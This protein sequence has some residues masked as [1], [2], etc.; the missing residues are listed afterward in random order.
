MCRVWSCLVVAY[1][2]PLSSLL[3]PAQVPRSLPL[4]TY[5]ITRLHRPRP[6]ARRPTPTRHLP[7]HASA[8]QLH[9]ARRIRYSPTI[10]LPFSD[11][12][13]PAPRRHERRNE[14]D[15][16]LPA[17]MEALC[18]APSNIRQLSRAAPTCTTRQYPRAPPA[19][20]FS[21]HTRHPFYSQAGLP[22]TP[23]LGRGLWVGSIPIS[24]GTRRVKCQAPTPR[25]SEKV[26]RA[27]HANSVS[28]QARCRSARCSSRSEI[29]AP[30]R[31]RRSEIGDRR[32]RRSGS[33]HGCGDRGS[34]I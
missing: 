11:V 9:S 8:H 3:A 34:E 10:T 30:S 15:S 22:T 13:K 29:R 32:G 26:P 14:L 24:L 19:T 20:P 16:R 23:S 5:T 2:C 18:V 6:L 31:D 33:P 4:A 28:M 7:T 21:L 17:F 27:S 1:N 25:T 12:A